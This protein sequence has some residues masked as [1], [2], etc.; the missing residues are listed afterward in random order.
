MARLVV[1]IDEELQ[2]QIK[3]KAVNAQKS[4]KDWVTELL[5]KAVKEK[6]QK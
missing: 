2:H 3:V 4:I 1:E 5:K 6:D